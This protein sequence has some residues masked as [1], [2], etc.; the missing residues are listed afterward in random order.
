VWRQTLG[1]ESNDVK[2]RGN[3]VFLSKFRPVH[4]ISATGEKLIKALFSH[5]VGIQA[6]SGFA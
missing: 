6:I 4:H 5:Y 1:D 2:A 3:N